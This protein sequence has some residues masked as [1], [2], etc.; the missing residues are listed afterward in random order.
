MAHTFLTSNHQNK[1]ICLLGLLVLTLSMLQT[2]DANQF[3]VGGTGRWGPD[4]T[5]Y[6]QW[7]EKNRF[8][9][10]DTIAFD[11]TAGNDSLIVVHNKE[12]YDNCTTDSPVQNFTDGHTVYTFNQSGA[13]YFI[14]GNKDNC[15]NKNQ[16]LIVVVLADRSNR[17]SNQTNSAMSPLSNSTETSPSPAPAAGSVEMNPTPSPTSEIPPPP[18][19][20]SAASANLVSFIAYIGA[21]AASSLLLVF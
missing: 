20:P 2:S 4:S 1:A 3:Q 11:Y 15:L 19:P 14:S 7:A 18:P 9:I 12:D 6:N 13:Y 17:Y 5:D 8:Q 16:K 21:F 10:G